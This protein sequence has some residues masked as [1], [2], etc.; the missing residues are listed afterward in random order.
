LLRRDHGRVVGVWE[1]AEMAGVNI[2]AAVCNWTQP[3]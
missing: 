3:G 2:E 1:V